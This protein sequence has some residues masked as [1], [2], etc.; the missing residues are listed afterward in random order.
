MLQEF[1]SDQDLLFF[2]FHA[3]AIGT[4]L[5]YLVSYRIIKQ[6]KRKLRSQSKAYEQLLNS[7]DTTPATLASSKKHLQ[8][9]R[10]DTD[11]KKVSGLAY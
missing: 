5:G 1:L 6:I 2:T 10:M 8:V 7:F 4:L 11:N 3:F 9:I